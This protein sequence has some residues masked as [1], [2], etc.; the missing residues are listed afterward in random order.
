[1]TARFI[2]GDTR[3]VLA[4]LPAQSV[5][6]VITSPPFLALRSY[7]PADHPDKHLEMGSEGTP[8]AFLDVLLDVVEGCR[9]VLAPHGSICIELG[10]TYSGGQTCAATSTRQVG[11]REHRAERAGT[12]A[13]GGDRL[14]PVNAGDGWPL[15]KSLCLI[16]ELFRIALVYGFNPLT[17]RTTERW[18]ARNVIRWARPNPP[19]GA[20][21]DKMRPATTDM[22]VA[23]TGRK[24]Y[25]DLDAVRHE[26][27]GGPHKV[28][29]AMVAGQP[30]GTTTGESNPAGAPPLDHWWHDDVFDQDAWNIPT[31]PYKGAHYA[32]WPPALLTKPILA[33]CPQKVCLECGQPSERI[34]AKTDE[35]Q[36]FR[37]AKLA[38]IA[39]GATTVRDKTITPTGFANGGKTMDAEFV[40]VG[41]SDCGHDSWRPGMIL[42]P[43]AGSGTTGAVATGHGRDAILI[44]LDPRNAELAQSRVGMFLT[45]TEQEPTA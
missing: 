37:D 40:T 4:T 34:V 30:R 11:T 20:L 42:D 41:W 24:R 29:S 13:D 39:S 43:F 23:C 27:K 22:V 32:T 25:F 36:R 14:V 35:Y 28:G 38:Q 19:V 5:D 2:V 15:D 12:G 18:R 31:A 33:M 26:H 16:P 6:L 8:G 3:Q 21:G 1:M 10:D 7:L 44:D 17:G 45:V 9:R